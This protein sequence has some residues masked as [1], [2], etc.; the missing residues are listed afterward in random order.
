MAATASLAHEAGSKAGRGHHRILLGA[1]AG[2]GKTFRMLLEGQQAADTGIDVVIGYLEPH[3]RKDTI[4]VAQGLENAPRRRIQHAG[5]WLE[6]MDVDAVLR[7][8]PELALIDELAHTNAP[9]GRNVKRYEDIAEV[10][11]AGIDV[12][13]TVNIQHLESLNDVIF[14]VT[15]VRVR[16]TFPDQVLDDADEVV[17]VDLTP[18]ELRERIRAG[19][20]YPQDRVDT[21]LSNFFAAEKLSSLRQLALREV[22]EDVQ[23]RQA[24]PLIGEASSTLIRDRILVLVEPRPAAQRLMRRAWRSGQRLGAADVDALWAHRPGASLTEDERVALAALRRLAVLL[25]IHFLEEE[26]AD[27]VTAVARV[28]QDR[29]TT[30][31]F[32][33]A[34]AERRL[35]LILG[36]SLLHRLVEALPGV[37]IRLCAD[38]SKRARPEP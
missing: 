8:V 24:P 35:D 23:A 1:A 29:G 12:I 32:L 26:D 9:G 30:Y 36:R 38:R 16:E 14:E 18:E 15:G 6:E 10:L 25:G 13:S 33:E 22:A 21:A 2:V 4:D 20:V 27:P 19:K 17:L 7:R 5:V 11:A 31:V 37:D 28:A 34:P 3:D